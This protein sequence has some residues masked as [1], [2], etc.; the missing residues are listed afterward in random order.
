LVFGLFV[1]SPPVLLAAYV[2]GAA[3]VIVVRD[4]LSGLKLAF[5]VALF[6]V[7]GALA[8]AIFIAISGVG[9]AHDPM[10]WLAAITAAVTIDVVGGLLVTAAISLRLG[11]LDAEG[12]GWLVV[13]GAVAAAANACFALVAVILFSVAPTSVMLLG[14]I[15][16]AMF[17]AYRAFVSLRQRHS[18]LEVL[19]E[20]TTALGRTAAFE[21]VAL[22]ALHEARQ[23]LQA[24]RAEIWFLPGDT[25]RDGVR[26]A[27]DGDDVCHHDA[28]FRIPIT[29][30]LWGRLV[31]ASAAVV[32]PRSTRDAG[33]RDLLMHYRCDDLVAA[34]LLGEQGMAGVVLLRDRQGDVGTFDDAD[35]RLL[36]ALGRYT[37]IALENG[38]LVDALQSEAARREHQALHD[39]LTDLP[40]RRYLIERG[41]ELLAPAEAGST[42]AMLLVDLDG[43]KEIND[44]FGHASG[45]AVLVEVA[46]RLRE[47]VDDAATL[48]RLGGDE[49]ALLV[50][51][52]AAAGEAVDYA[53]RIRQALSR[54]HVVNRVTVQL[55]MNAGIAL[56]PE[57]GSSVSTLLRC[58]DVAM[59]QARDE[60]TS[61]CIYRADKDSHTPE[62][63]A[64]AA[65]LRAAL[66]EGSL[67][68]GYQPIKALET[69]QIVNVEVL[70]R[71]EHPTRGLLPP[72]VYIEVAEQSDLIRQLTSYVLQHA[73]EQ[74]RRWA[75]RGLELTVSVN[76]SVHD[77]NREGFAAEVAHLLAETG[78]P[79]RRLVLELTETQALHHPERI[80]PV[81]ADLRRDGVVVAID[82]FGTG[83][84]S[85]TSLRSLPID[86]IKIDKSFVSTMTASEHDN[87]IVRSIIEL[88]R[89]LKLEI[90]AEGVED[91]DTEQQLRELGCHHIQGYVLTKALPAHELET[92]L[93]REFQQRVTDANVLPMRRSS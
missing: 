20:Y 19:Q 48:V 55:D 4:R 10:T 84:S 27:L 72:P 47:I 23:R 18:E 67:A 73:L 79:R 3:A 46:D 91:E 90:V 52:L 68:L 58:A 32:I 38:R 42:A 81:L 9:T 92:W 86:E 87:A 5:N 7:E 2:L 29:D 8:V 62:R 82:D 57:H 53:N 59:W 49:F 24:E 69:D 15:G 50:P 76:V 61:A 56:Y 75:E 66:A 85:L 41:P 65:D 88:G 44:T 28:N 43:L 36:S 39:Q 13:F 51:R 45:D 17:G 80:A 74:R 34:P 26:I 33:D 60:R 31:S 78:T 30:A 14:V 21:D 11:H 83:Y 71:W 25:D 35:G 40:N 93:E 37:S 70:S 22:A 63:L 1:L 77:L 54:P 64:L 16:A 6:L 12:T 89:R